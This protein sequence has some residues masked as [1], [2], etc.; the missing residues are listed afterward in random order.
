MDGQSCKYVVCTPVGTCGLSQI[1]TY[2]LRKYICTYVY[3]Y[4]KEKLLQTSLIDWAYCIQK[5]TMQAIHPLLNGLLFVT[6]VQLFNG[7][8]IVVRGHPTTMWTNFDIPPP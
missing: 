2:C 1:F 6:Q 5:D 7:F 8:S 4:R 3:I